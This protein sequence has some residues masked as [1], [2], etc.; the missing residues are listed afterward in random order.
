M[1]W[2]QQQHLM[3]CQLY[4]NF[5][6]KRHVI[7]DHADVHTAVVRGFAKTCYEV[8]RSGGQEGYHMLD[9]EQ[10]GLDPIPVFCNMSSHPITAVL[11]HNL[12]ELT[13][14]QGYEA[15]GSYNGQVC[16]VENDRHGHQGP[17]L[18]TWIAFN[19]NIEK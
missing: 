13:Y 5:V 1:I 11:H 17:I 3:M 16:H 4:W 15:T 2:I 9:P 10:D 12:E 8:Q 14:V 18:L 6:N 19:L 7:G